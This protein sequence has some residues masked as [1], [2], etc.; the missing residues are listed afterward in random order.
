MANNQGRVGDPWGEN[1]ATQQVS[2][3]VVAATPSNA[4]TYSGADFAALT[5]GGSK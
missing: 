2:N 1:V 4:I 5:K 3:Y